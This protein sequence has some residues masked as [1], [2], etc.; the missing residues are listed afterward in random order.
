MSKKKILYL[1]CHETLEYD[2]LKIMTELGLDCFSLGYYLDPHNPTAVMRPRLDIMQPNPNLIAEFKRIC[3]EYLEPG[4][5]T[6]GSGIVQLTQEFMDKFDGYV[7]CHYPQ[8]LKRNLPL[9]GDKPVIYRSIAA[10]DVFCEALVHHEYKNTRPFSVVRM[11][12]AEL[13]VNPKLRGDAFIRQ[14]VDSS[15]FK[16]WN[17]A[18][19]STFCVVKY[20]KRRPDCNFDLYETVNHDFKK[21]LCGDGNEDIPYATNNPP[22][23]EMVRLMQACRVHY[24]QPRYGACISYSFAESLIMGGPIVTLGKKYMG[25]HWEA[26]KILANGINGFC[27]ST[28]DEAR[29]YIEMLMKDEALARR[30]S[31]KGKRLAMS[32][33][34]Y[35]VVKQQWASVLKENQLL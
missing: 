27:A 12:P 5:K 24:I 13:E 14:S 10:P 4:C 18:D 26:S 9:C 21:V 29:H 34:D 8:N 32:M 30:I 6:T 15:V 7:F 23:E 33:F 19:A 16:D 22:V 2:E 17:G 1:S 11:S 28:M 31:A 35:G 20:F 25:P 3:P